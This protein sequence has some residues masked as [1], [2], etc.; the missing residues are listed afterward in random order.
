MRKNYELSIDD[1][2]AKYVLFA[3]DEYLY[4]DKNKTQKATERQVEHSFTKGLI[5]KF[6]NITIYPTS[7]ERFTPS[8]EVPYVEV[9]FINESGVNKLRS[10]NVGDTPIGEAV[11]SVN[12][13]TGDVLLSFV[14]KIQIDPDTGQLIFYDENNYEIG[15][16]ADIED[17]ADL[18]TKT[19]LQNE[20]TARANAISTEQTVRANADSALQTVID[21]EIEARED[22]YDTLQTNITAEETERIEAINEINSVIPT[23]AT[24]TNKLATQEYVAGEVASANAHLITNGGLPFESA[25]D[26]PTTGVVNNDYAYVKVEGSTTG[27]FKFIRYKFSD[28]TNTWQQE[29]ELGQEFTTEEWNAITSGITA[30][31]VALITTNQT[32]IDSLQTTLANNYY[33]KTQATPL[34]LKFIDEDGV[35]HIYKVLEVA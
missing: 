9:T 7:I 15:R 29:I 1:D 31:A 34:Q 28:T 2:V 24:S 5:I 16:I 19:E 3:D 26:L 17:I 35:E 21:N 25:S 20:I 4:V 10:T 22:A 13:Q 12:G 14:K 8:G 33:S 6:D 11:T 23:D 32:N 18:A 27:Y 30:T